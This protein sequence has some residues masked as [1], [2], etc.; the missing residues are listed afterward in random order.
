MLTLAQQ[1]YLGC[2]VT[3]DGREITQFTHYGDAPYVIDGTEYRLRRYDLRDTLE[4]PLGVMASAY[5]SGRREV[6]VDCHPHQLV[7]RRLTRLGK[8]W[9]VRVHGEP[10]GT[11]RVRTFDAAGDFP[12]EIPLPVRVFALHT[13][14][15]SSGGSLLSYLPWF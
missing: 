1:G 11:C 8:R 3:E 7:L 13:V 14:L 15:M 6:T 9:E 5:S 12:A 2:L 10:A 4:G